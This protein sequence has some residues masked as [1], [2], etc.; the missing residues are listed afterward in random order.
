MAEL[1]SS[2]LAAK[3]LKQ[4]VNRWFIFST[5]SQTDFDKMLC[6]IFR[7][8]CFSELLASQKIAQ[9]MGPGLVMVHTNHCCFS[10]FRI[11]RDALCRAMTRFLLQS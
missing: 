4:C 1:I 2:F 10:F 5:N 11:D 6:I 8:A 9:K 3:Q 7:I